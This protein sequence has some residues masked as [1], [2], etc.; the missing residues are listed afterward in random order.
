MTKLPSLA[1]PAPLRGA[2]LPLLISLDVL[3]EEC[4]VTRAAG[5]LNLSQP[6]LSAQLSR[7]RLLFDDPLLVPAGSGRGLAP[8]PAALQLQRRLRPALAALAAALRPG[9][10]GFDPAR[11]ARTFHVV[12]NNTAA[13][14]LLPS[15]A[16]RLQAAGNDQ[17]RLAVAAPDTGD[18]AGRL[19]RGEVD[20]CF[21]PACHLPPG[22]RSCELVTAP[23][24]LVQRRGHFRGDGPITLAEYATL[25]HVNVSPDGSLHGALDEQLY[26]LGHARRT[27]LGVRDYTAIGAIVANSDLVCTMPAFLAGGLP[28]TAV[29]V[30]LAFPFLDYVLCMAWHPC[31]D[32]DPGLLWLRAQVQAAMLPAPAG[33]R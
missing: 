31:G 20:L 10:D 23:Y 15:L 27:L 3:L 8:T 33:A 5:R 24:V 11:A 25:Q 12:A 13:A 6:A 21:G 7:L 18:L 16:G 2:D 1:R 26:R 19:E 29:A 14:V 9:G 28:A 22:L 4:N 17:L 30:D 32:D